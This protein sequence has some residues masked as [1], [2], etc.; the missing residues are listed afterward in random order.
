[1]RDHSLQNESDERQRYECG[2]ENP[3]RW[4]FYWRRLSGRYYLKK[5]MVSQP[6]KYH[7]TY[8]TL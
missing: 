4:E 8:S 1:L 6:P 2:E 3:F 5:S 7:D